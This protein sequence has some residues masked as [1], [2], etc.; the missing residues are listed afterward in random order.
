M[1]AANGRVTY[2]R[3]LRYAMRAVAEL[4]RHVQVYSM[5]REYDLRMRSLIYSGNGGLYYFTERTARNGPD[6]VY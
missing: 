4:Y 3:E 6:F 2:S 1:T 5:N